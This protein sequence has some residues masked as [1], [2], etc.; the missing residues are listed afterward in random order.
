M[1]REHFWSTLED[2][3][4]PKPVSLHL[5]LVDHKGRKTTSTQ[6]QEAMKRYS[7][8]HLGQILTIQSYCEI[9]I[10]ISY[11]FISEQDAFMKDFDGIDEGGLDEGEEEQGVGRRLQAIMDKQASH[12]SS[13]TGMIYA[14]LISERDGTVAST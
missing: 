7:R 5:W 3:E 2:G 9:T 10:A 14:Q 8:E 13:V 4:A 12:T 6:M 1:E 11:R